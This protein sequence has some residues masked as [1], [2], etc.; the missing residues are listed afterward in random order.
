[1]KVVLNQNLKYAYLGDAYYELSVRKY[2]YKK[3]PSFNM[4]TLHKENTS[5]SCCGMQNAIIKKLQE[6]NFLTEDELNIFKLARNE[7]TSSHPKNFTVN[8]YRNATGFEAVVGYLLVN[9]NESRASEIITKGI[10][11]AEELKNEK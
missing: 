9:D 10:E 1:M 6:L 4:D 5:F 8:E 3:Y 11:I 7:K 2:L